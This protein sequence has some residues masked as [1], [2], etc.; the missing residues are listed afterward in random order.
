MPQLYEQRNSGQSML[1]VWAELVCVEGDE[2]LAVYNRSASGFIIM[3]NKMPNS[4]D[5]V[6]TLFSIYSC[7]M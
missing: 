5:F 3:W 2:D 1:S 6:Q 4:L 7:V